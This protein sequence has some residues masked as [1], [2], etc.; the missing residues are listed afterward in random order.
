MVNI[1]KELLWRTEPKDV[2]E[3]PKETV[4]KNKKRPK[5]GSKFKRNKISSKKQIKE[6]EEDV[7]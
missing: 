4:F 5:K 1:V 7:E 6:V 3:E 2:V